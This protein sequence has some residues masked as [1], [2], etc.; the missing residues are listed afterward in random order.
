MF[1]NENDCFLI[2]INNRMIEEGILTISSG[3]FSLCV[4]GP[5]LYYI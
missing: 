4:G 2:Y 1:A 3:L 5:T